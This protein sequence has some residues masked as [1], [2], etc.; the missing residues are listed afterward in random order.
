MSSSSAFSSD[1]SEGSMFMKALSAAHNHKAKARF[2]LFEL[3]QKLANSQG[4]I[5]PKEWLQ[6]KELA[7]QAVQMTAVYIKQLQATQNDEVNKKN[8]IVRNN[9]F[10]PAPPQVRGEVAKQLVDLY[11]KEPADKD[12]TLHLFKDPKTKQDLSDLGALVEIMILYITGQPRNDEFALDAKANPAFEIMITEQLIRQMARS[13][14]ELLAEDTIQLIDLDHPSLAIHNSAIHDDYM[15]RMRNDLGLITMATSY[16]SHSKNRKLDRQSTSIY[17]MT[18]SQDDILPIDRLGSLY[19][20]FDNITVSP[21]P[22]YFVYWFP[23]I[24]TNKDKK[25]PI[26]PFKLADVSKN[27]QAFRSLLIGKVSVKDGKIQSFEMG[28]DISKYKPQENS[29]SSFGLGWLPSFSSSRKQTVQNIPGD[30]KSTSTSGYGY[31]KSGLQGP[32]IYSAEA[33][34]IAKA[35]EMFTNITG[36]STVQPIVSNVA[37]DRAVEFKKFASELIPTLQFLLNKNVASNK[38]MSNSNS[39]I[40]YAA[41]FVIK[42]DLTVF[43]LNGVWYDILINDSQTRYKNGDSVIDTKNF[44]FETFRP[45]NKMKDVYELK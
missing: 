20:S 31:E 38:D 29:S 21:D 39:P 18:G 8:F 6:D 12:Y 14:S 23:A 22:S 28:D 16:I 24:F 10:L 15:I 26:T 43:S 30:E 36:S 4:K 32:M 9:T 42:S 35:N 27:N 41:P 34:L 40:I 33:N 7:A 3:S 11:H 37:V 25:T 19:L 5:I 44:G 1:N 13:K 17:K 2:T 45:L